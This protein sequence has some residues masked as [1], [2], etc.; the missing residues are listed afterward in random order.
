[1]V[2]SW[3]PQRPYQLTLRQWPLSKA[4]AQKG[5]ICLAVRPSPL[6][7]TKQVLNAWLAMHPQAFFY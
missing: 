4:A 3:L 1:M 6:R 5:N 7:F 2:M